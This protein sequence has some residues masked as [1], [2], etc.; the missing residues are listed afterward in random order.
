MGQKKNYWLMKSEPNTYS[1]DDL[2]KDKKTIWDG[3]RNYQARNY[4]MRN[5]QVGD[6][7]LF[8]HSSANPPAVAGIAIVSKEALPDP[9]QFDKKS[10]YYDPQ[11]TQETPRWYCVELAYQQKF[12]T[13][14]SLAKL[15]EIKDLK[16]MLVLKKG[17]RLSIQPVQ[18]KEF[19]T[20]LK[21]GKR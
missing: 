1:I 6:A 9:T 3:V 18:K 11:S 2:K 8:Y 5:M 14:V 13:F 19:E 15:R 7:V 20:V 17:Q 16:N 10:P 21:L 12:K 4:M